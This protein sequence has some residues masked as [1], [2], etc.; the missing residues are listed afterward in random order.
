MVGGVG[1]DS[2]VLVLR[3]QCLSVAISRQGAQEPPEPLTA[4]IKPSWRR[5]RRS[6]MNACGN[7]VIR[8]GHVAGLMCQLFKTTCPI[9]SPPGG[10]VVPSSGSDPSTCSDQLGS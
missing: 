6:R 9:S 4:E 1:V 8:R 7:S 10:G 3:M 2:L 5:R